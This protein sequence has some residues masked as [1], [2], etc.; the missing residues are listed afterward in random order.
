MAH[1]S[2]L[3]ALNT[4]RFHSRCSQQEVVFIL[5]VDMTEADIITARVK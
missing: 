2:S 3:M 4:N 1:K 5:N